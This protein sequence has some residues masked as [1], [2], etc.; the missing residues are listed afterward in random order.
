MNQRKGRVLCKV[1]ELRVK[2]KLQKAKIYY[3]IKL[4]YFYIRFL[5]FW[6][7]TNDTYIYILKLFKNNSLNIFKEFLFLSQNRI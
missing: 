2:H 4:L 5:T 3:G 1:V 6:N 7:L